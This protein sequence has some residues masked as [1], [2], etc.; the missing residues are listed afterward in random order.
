MSQFSVLRKSY[1][2]AKELLVQRNDGDVLKGEVKKAISLF[3]VLFSTWQVLYLVT[4]SFP[5]LNEYWLFAYLVVLGAAVCFFIL[6]KQKARDLGLRKPKAWKKYVATSFVFAVFYNVYWA[7]AGTPIFSTG[8]ILSTQHGIFTVPYNLLFALTVGLVEETSFRGYILRNLNRVY[9]SIR[10]IA[11]SSILFGLYHLSLVYA[12]TSTTSA[13][14]TLSYWTLFMLAAVLIGVFLGYFYV[15][16]EKTTVGTVTYHSLSIFIE[17]LVPFAL[18][19]TLLSG[20]LLS[21][22]VYVIF[23]PLLVVL[24]KKGWLT[25][26]NR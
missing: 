7:V 25:S 15:C 5:T 10:A 9:S 4:L 8:P 16:T 23:I 11:Y 1:N 14:E 26:T 21:T 22:T 18:A 12:F 20:H 17:S 2:W 3:L 24:R 13:F 19:T 6:D